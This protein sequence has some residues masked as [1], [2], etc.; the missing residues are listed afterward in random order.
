MSPVDSRSTCSRADCSKSDLSRHA[1][2]NTARGS[3]YAEEA[4]R[5]AGPAASWLLH[6]LQV[7]R[8]RKQAPE[9]QLCASY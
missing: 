2:H 4:A 6:D 8:R 3:L 9:N 7:P 1:S 5:A